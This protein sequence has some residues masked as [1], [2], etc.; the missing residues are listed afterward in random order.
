MKRGDQMV[1][2]KYRSP[3]KL[4]VTVAFSAI[5]STSCGD[6]IATPFTYAGRYSPTID[7]AAV[8]TNAD[9]SDR[10]ILEA[11]YEATGGAGWENR[12]NW[13]TDE[14]LNRW[15]GVT[16]TQGRV[17]ELELGYNRLI[18]AV[19]P[20]L[21][22]LSELTE[23]DLSGNQLEGEIP[24]ELGSLS[25]LWYLDLHGNHLEGEIP[26]ELGSLP[27]LIYLRL[28]KNNLEGGIPPEL[29][30][31]PALEDLSLS[32]NSLTGNIPPL[33]SLTSLE[34]L[35]LHG[36]RITGRIPETLG[37]LS[38]LQVLS[39]SGN[40]LEGPIPPELGSLIELKELLLS[41]NRLDGRI[42][43]ELGSVGSGP[44]GSGRISWVDLSGNRLEGP[45]PPELSSL[46]KHG[47]DRLNLSDNQL[48]GPI[49]GQLASGTGVEWLDL[50]DNQ[51]EGPIPEELVSALAATYRNHPFWWLDLSGNQLTGAIPSALGSI[52]KLEWLD[53]SGN[54]LEDRI[55]SSLGSLGDL[56]LLDLSGNRLEDGI[57]PELGSLGNLRWL[58]LSG[59]QLE[60]RIPP[61]LGDV[62]YVMFGSVRVRSNI[63]SV[64][65][66]GNQLE[67]CI[68]DALSRFVS[69]INSQSGG[70]VVLPVCGASMAYLT[71]AIGR[72]HKPDFL[73]SIDT[74]A[75]HLI[76]NR[77]ALLRVFLTPG[78]GMNTSTLPVPVVAKFYVNGDLAYKEEVSVPVVMDVAEAESSLSK[79]GNKVIPGRVIQPGLELVID[80]DPNGTVGDGLGLPRNIPE[81]GRRPVDVDVM[82]P[83]RLTVVPLLL[84][85]DPDS[86]VIDVAYRMEE[87]QGDH[88]LL[89]DALV[90]LPLGDRVRVTTRQPVLVSSDN[91]S[92]LY[93][94]IQMIRRLEYSSS[95]HVDGHYMGIM[96]V[97]PTHVGALG[98][99]GISWMWDV[100][101]SSVVKLQY[102]GWDAWLIAHE[103]GHN[104]SLKHTPCGDPANVDEGFPDRYGRIVDWGYDIRD[105][106]LVD[107]ST[108]DFMSYCSPSWTSGYSFEKAR[109]HRL[110]RWASDGRGQMSVERQRS[111]LVWG[112]VNADGEP[113]LEPAFVLDGV[114][115]LPSTGAGR[116]RL[117]GRS[118][119]GGEL[120]NLRFD[121][122]EV[123]DGDGSSSFAFVL[124][125]QPGWEGN[126]AR[127]MLVGPSGSVSLDEETDSQM[128]ILRDSQTGQVRSILR[129]PAL[130]VSP[131]PGIEVLFSRGIPSAD[132]WRR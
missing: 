121:M 120:F 100:R 116:Y 46:A 84:A 87:E 132:A 80:V 88:E 51:L 10:A 103:L 68:P 85:S 69:T 31:L 77:D 115:A 76:A 7:A 79:S 42:P 9:V 112:G 105:G 47:L 55:P 96:G 40:R 110:S 95:L 8:S 108:R 25:E 114:P 127:I 97:P 23:L 104:L 113:Y 62:G 102:S 17:T 70:N 117:V 92:R 89:S 61:E 29:G 49:P 37:S 60:G 82:P 33:D 6:G 15:H 81:T 20:E 130:S 16:S 119:E 98:Y 35:W 91:T 73:N 64:H 78:R 22:G 45:I 126:L 123:A 83:F 43:P 41:G 27:K 57:P 107:P 3:W 19:P 52:S 48:E 34:G 101:R 26:L 99:A 54:Q 111:I 131:E 66:S 24:A 71:Q 39:L 118:A 13:L 28:H 4:L 125:V 21:G 94:F 86:S 58:D 109:E 124:P 32:E 1:R 90:L 128:A 93:T 56:Q 106:V 38:R 5:V 30:R 59:N 44:Y 75:V 50:S 74:S 65:L 67:G 18:G 2:V 12:G 53:L 63:E 11:L 36:N 14:P 129:D 122:P 72:R